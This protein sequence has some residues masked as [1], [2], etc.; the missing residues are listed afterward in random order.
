MIDYSN[1]LTLLTSK[2]LL[3]EEFV[4]DY[5]RALFPDLRHLNNHSLRGH[6]ERH[7]RA[8]GRSASPGDH[9]TGFLSVVSPSAKVL[10]IG[11]FTVPLLRGPNVRYFD[12]LDRDGLL[13]RARQHG[14]PTGDIPNIDF[15]SERG[16]LSVVSGQ[17]DYV[18][19]AHC[20]EH[21]PD[22]I[23]HLQQAAD[24]LHVGGRYLLIVPDAR[25]CFDH[26][27]PLSS[28]A[29]MVEAH[30][31]KRRVHTAANV[32]A[33][34]AQTTHND[35][36]AHWR[37]EHADPRSDQVEQRKLDAAAALAEANGGY[38]DVHAWTLTPNTFREIMTRM[39]NEGRAP[40]ALERVYNTLN[41]S[42]EFNASLVRI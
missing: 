25:Y 8:E 19:S 26:F 28:F 7:G 30:A 41:G 15:V 21:V 18:I 36:L 9:R 20:I 6:Y 32:T 42:N 34:F 38:I 31:E 4:A 14:Y 17:F 11:P 2:D 40:F 29:D 37:G 13:E 12:V 23:T 10:E 16:D 5:Y 39:F 24:L 27:R 33:Y 3:P 22:L 35:P 1:L